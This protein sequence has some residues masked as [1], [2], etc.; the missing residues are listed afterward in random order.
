MTIG[1]LMGLI[2]FGAVLI[3]AG[4]PPVAERIGAP[5]FHFIERHLVML[6]PT[7]LVMFATSLLSP[8]WIKVVALLA[9]AGSMAAL[10][11]TLFVGVEI[12]G[13]QRWLSVAGFSLQPSEFVKPAFAVVSA[14]ILTDLTFRYGLRQAWSAAGMIWCG[15]V[16]LLISQPDFGMTLLVTAIFGSQLFVAGLPLSVVAVGLALTALGGFGAY[17]MLPHVQSRIDRFLSPDIGDNYQVARSI[18]AFQNGGLLGVGPGEGTVKFR[19]PDAHADFIFPV[20]GEELG[21]LL[22]LLM[23][24]LFAFVLARGCGRLNRQT[25]PFVIVAAAGLLV[26]FGLQALINV[27]SAVALI[28]TKGMTL[29]FVSY[30]GSS[31]IA[32]GLAMGMLLSLTRLRTPA[33]L[34]Q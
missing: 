11:A 17:H 25:Q 3:A 10:V 23:V 14:W 4:S 15:L 26:Q 12:K 34:R 7:L 1:A 5:K 27:A 19:V 32:L 33:E 16:I 29:P 18:E 21:F 24:G 6:A 20:A 30:G 31:L 8:R 22:T 28:P 13:A 9:L 2:A